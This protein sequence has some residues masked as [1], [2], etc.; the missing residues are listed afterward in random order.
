MPQDL[1]LG[2][3]IILDPL[4]DD[5]IEDELSTG[6]RQERSSRAGY[7][8]LPG[9]N[10]QPDP[11][12][13]AAAAAAAEVRIRQQEAEEKAEIAAAAAE[14][15]IRHEEEEEEEAAAKQAVLLRQVDAK[16][17][18]GSHATSNE[19]TESMMG[20]SSENHALFDFY[21]ELIE[22]MRSELETARCEVL[23]CEEDRMKTQE[24]NVF[25]R[26]ALK[27]IEEA[28]LLK[29][30]E[31]LKL[32]SENI[33]LLEVIGRRDQELENL[34]MEAGFNQ[35]VEELKHQ[36]QKRT[37]DAEKKDKA[38]KELQSMMRGTVQL[39]MQGPRAM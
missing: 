33:E 11:K 24:D 37:P 1:E 17:K 9:L 7:R 36:L 23:R 8:H 29:E 39:E 26:D 5:K 14:A 16:R 27:K 13:A 28:L 34:N 3:G 30:E 31:R 4:V 35:V 10:V 21:S 12:A 38:M 2:E 20:N 25:I 22:N 32:E 15:W 18:N 6:G 19:K